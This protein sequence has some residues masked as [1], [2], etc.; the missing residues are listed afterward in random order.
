M[1]RCASC[2]VAAETHCPAQ[3]GG[4]RPAHPRYCE[5]VARDPATWSPLIQA[6]SRH[7]PPPPPPVPTEVPAEAVAGQHLREALRRIQSC[8]YRIPNKLAGD[9]YDPEAGGCGCLAVCLAGFGRQTDRA[10]GRECWHCPLAE[11]IASPR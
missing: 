10:V 9:S 7:E 6:A 8:D 5:L 4:P 3:P 2:P 11:A 1:N